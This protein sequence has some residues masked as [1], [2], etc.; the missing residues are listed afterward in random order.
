MSRQEIDEFSE[1]FNKLG[2]A[3]DRGIGLQ[4]AMISSWTHEKVED[5]SEKIDFIRRSVCLLQSS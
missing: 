3:L 2:K 5:M 1:R 4:S